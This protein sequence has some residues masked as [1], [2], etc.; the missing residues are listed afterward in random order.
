MIFVLGNIC[1]DTTFYV[2]RLPLPGE[3][4]NATATQAGLGGKGLNQALAA[5]STGARVKLVAGVGEDWTESDSGLLHAAG[6][7]GPELALVRKAGLV[8]CSS[9]IVAASGENVIVTNAAQA[10]ALSVADIAPVLAPGPSDI[11]LLQCNLQPEITMFAAELAKRSGARVIFNPA[12]F[13]SWA[14]CLRELA[15]V[16]ILNR[17]EASAWTGRATAAEAIVELDVP[18]AIITLGMEGCLVRRHGEGMQQLPAPAT[19]AVDTTGAGDTFAGV[20]AAEW[21]ATGDESRAIGLALRAAS[22][23]V[24]RRGAATAI[25]SQMEIDRLRRQFT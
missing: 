8:D 13:K 7:G 1:R 20:F 25:P 6:S 2:D 17:Q 21:Q 3:T 15:D 12:P 11:L 24:T 4:I 16:L 5:C 22:A 19:K 18:L 23:S 9:I 14:P 10:E